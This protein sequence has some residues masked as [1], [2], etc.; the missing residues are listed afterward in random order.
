MKTY[1]FHFRRDARY[2]LRLSRVCERLRADRDGA[3]AGVG[4]AKARIWREPVAARRAHLPRSHRR[5]PPPLARRNH[6]GRRRNAVA[7]SP[8]P[9][10]AQ[11]GLRCRH[12]RHHQFRPA[13]PAGRARRPASR[14]G[15]PQ[16]HV[17]PPARRGCRRAPFS[18]AAGAA[19]A[20]RRSRRLQTQ[21]RRARL[22]RP[23][24]SGR[25]IAAAA[26]LLLHPAIVHRRSNDPRSGPELHALDRLS[27]AQRGSRCLAGSARCFPKGWS[28]IACR[29]A[30]RTCGSTRL[31]STA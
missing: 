21:G 16:L 17:A 14:A 6:A 25:P 11:A 18:A 13:R 28:F 29:P 31:S 20:R 8:P 27:S 30:F 22:G 24:R 19:V 15:D 7:G 12:D 3:R 23:A 9:A 26:P 10:H 5:A 1:C 2:Q 4:R